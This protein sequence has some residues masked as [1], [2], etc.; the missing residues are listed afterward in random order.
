MNASDAEGYV[1]ANLADCEQ[2]RKLAASMHACK[3]MHALGSQKILSLGSG[4]CV[5]EWFLSRCLPIGTVVVATDNWG[6]L[7][8]DSR[9]YEKAK[10]LEPKIIVRHFDFLRG[11]IERLGRELNVLFDTV[12]FFGVTYLFDVEGLLLLLDKIWNSFVNYIVDICNYGHPMKAKEKISCYKRIWRSVKE[13]EI[14]PPHYIIV[15]GK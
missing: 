10:I 12:Y 5:Q 9:G 3:I 14:N 6:E 4:S 2:V 8:G 7:V 15:V 13:V 11:S 1:C